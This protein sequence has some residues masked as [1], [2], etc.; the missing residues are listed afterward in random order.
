MP[1]IH[2]L[3]NIQAPPTHGGIMGPRK[4]YG[5]AKPF[6]AISTMVRAHT[7]IAAGIVKRILIAINIAAGFFPAVFVCR[8]FVWLIRCS[9]PADLT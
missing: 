2:H 7:A 8:P 6:G 3:V 9:N 5:S 4:A 1:N